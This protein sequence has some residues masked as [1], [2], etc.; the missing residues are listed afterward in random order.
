MQYKVLYRKYRPDNF[1]NIVG[2]DHTKEILKN[3]I[4][5]NKIAHAYIFSG[6]RGTGK[7]STAK[8]F[9]KSINCLNSIDGEACGKCNNCLN[10]E[11]NTDI[12]EIDAASNNGVDQI[13]EITNNIKLAPTMSKYK[14][15]II[16]E[17]HMLS[18][19]AFNALLLTLEDPPSHIIFILATTNIE[20]VPI[21]ILSRCQRF[22]FKKIGFQ[23]IIDRL[24]YICEKEKIEIDEEALNEIAYISDGGL[25]DALSLL[26]QLS[27][28]D[29]KI[30]LQLVMDEVGAVSLK[31]VEKIVN[32]IEKNNALEIINKLREYKLNSLD[33]KLVVRKLIDVCMNNAEKIV[34]DGKIDRLSYQDYKKLVFDLTECLNKI[35]VNVEAYNLIELVLLDRVSFKVENS[36]EKKEVCLNVEQKLTNKENNYDFVDT[37]INNCFVYATKGDKNNASKKWKD[38]IEDIEDK[39]L[40]SYI[41]DSI[42]VL[43]SRD[44]YVILSSNLLVNEINQHSELIQDAYRKSC[45]SAIK[46]VAVDDKK[47]KFVSSEYINSIKNGKKYNYIDEKSQKKEIE[48]IATNLFSND[49]IEID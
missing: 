3:S 4:I 41:I 43:A 31:S 17:V 29:K 11:T 36:P 40:K 42:V 18:Q 32:N 19:S 9:A 35:N 45:N 15:Y 24:M 16:D 37:R 39:T 2:L 13:R 38:F 21:T 47:W 12:I 5:N 48:N 26:D 33:Y 25:R 46:I 34:S 23:Q 6:P 7:T 10:F 14:V 22:D 27:K 44:I 20:S 49:K 28:A 8:V 30:T 1:N